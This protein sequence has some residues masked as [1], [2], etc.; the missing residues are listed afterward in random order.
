MRRTAR[1]SA[2]HGPRGSAP[3]P[4]S[5]DKLSRTLASTLVRVPGRVQA[6]LRALS[7]SVFFAGLAKRAMLFNLQQVRRYMT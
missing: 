1:I 4:A 6:G 3:R 7:G 5:A 2:A